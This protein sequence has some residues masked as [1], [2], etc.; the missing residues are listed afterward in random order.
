MYAVRYVWTL[1]LLAELC[2]SANGIQ[3]NVNLASPV[4]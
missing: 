3:T 4:T 1:V 2:H